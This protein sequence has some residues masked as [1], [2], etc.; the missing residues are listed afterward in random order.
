MVCASRGRRR[1]GQH[2]HPI[3]RVGRRGCDRGR[4]FRSIG[5]R[6]SLCHQRRL[7]AALRRAG[8]DAAVRHGAARQSDRDQSRDRAGRADL[9]RRRQLRRR[10]DR[11]RDLCGGLRARLHA[12]FHAR[13]RA[14]RQRR[15]DPR[16]ADQRGRD[17]EDRC[18]AC[19]RHGQGLAGAHG[20]RIDEQRRRRAERRRPA[21]RRAAL[22]AGRSLGA[23]G[24]EP[25]P[26][27]GGDARRGDGPACRDRGAA[28]AGQRG[29]HPAAQDPGRWRQRLLHP[30]AGAGYRPFGGWR[31]GRHGAARRAA[32]RRER[33]ELVDGA[34][35]ARR[36][37]RGTRPDPESAAQD[38]RSRNPMP[39]RHGSTSSASAWTWRG[40][41]ASR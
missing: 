11:L 22:Y 14:G 8:R 9:R 34:L 30:A 27:R 19:H 2:R 26:D 6:P 25:Q 28:D 1:A 24:P 31:P 38:G 13:R 39:S 35:R 40:P 23:G 37:D 33:R 36:D 16:R 5:A 18:P 7:R 20:R 21:D 17:G 15:P 29:Q 12:Q 10:D 3:R 41:K 32:G 4:H